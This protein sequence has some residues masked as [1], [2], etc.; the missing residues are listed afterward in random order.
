MDMGGVVGFRRWLW[1]GL[2]VFGC[3]Y[4]REGWDLGGCV[5]QLLPAVE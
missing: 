4:V 1:D 2:W 5:S 3:C